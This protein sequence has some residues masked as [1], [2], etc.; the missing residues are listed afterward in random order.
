MLRVTK[1]VPAFGAG[2]PFFE[3]FPRLL[4]SFSISRS[5]EINKEL[6]TFRGKF[7]IGDVGNLTG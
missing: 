1:T 4:S 2:P 6:L 5:E 3:L 7:D